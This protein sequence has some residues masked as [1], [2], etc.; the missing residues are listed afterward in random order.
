[1]RIIGGRFRRRR[2][3][4]PARGVRPTSDRLRETLFNVLGPS[5]EGARV[6]DAFAGTGA[7]GL[8]ALSRGAAEV[9]LVERDPRALEVVA[10]NLRR[11]GAESGCRVVRGS[12]ARAVASMGP[13]DLVL[14]DPPYDEA[15]FEGILGAAAGVLAATGRVVLEHSRRRTSPETAGALTRARLLTAA[16]LVLAVTVLAACARNIDVGSP[17]PLYAIQI[18]N[19]L[20]EEM[21]VSYD[22]GAGIRALGTV[23][24]GGIERFLIN[25]PASTTVTVT[26]RNTS[27]TDTVGP[28]T[29]QLSSASTPLI[30]LQ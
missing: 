9:T 5:V 3:A 23:L 10:E 6:L 21:I 27:G 11:C 29:V 22:D 28:F 1:M 12:F 8:E 15:D 25:A 24:P 18:R 26:A 2:L 13:F 19:A 16:P 4:S 7:L 20:N 14:L 30:V 17:R